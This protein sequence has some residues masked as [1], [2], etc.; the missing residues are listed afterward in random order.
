MRPRPRRDG[1]IAQSVRFFR[2]RL[3]ERHSNFIAA[4]GAEG[5]VLQ[6]SD[7][8]LETDSDRHRLFDRVHC[9]RDA[10]IASAARRLAREIAE[11]DDVSPLEAE[12][13]ALVMFA[14][15]IDLEHAGRF[16]KP[17]QSPRWLTRAV[18]LVHD[19]FRE[20]LLV[21]DVAQAAGVH[22]AHL[23]VMFRRVHRVPLGD[24]VRRLR[25]DWAADQLDTTDRPLSAIAA[26]AGF[27]DQAHLTRWFRRL[28]GVT[29]RAFRNT[30]R[31]RREQLRID[32][33]ATERVS[34]RTPSVPC[35]S[36][37]T[38]DPSLLTT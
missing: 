16:L 34:Y 18:E 28:T 27:A 38:P 15:S 3:G 32:N 35:V 1:S 36:R 29:P 9:F 33:G 10:Y 22:P 14:E 30:R 4:R 31:S 11:P 7:A 20:R 5:V 19:R 12:S 26:E 17:N 23:A 13:L 6:P 25:V 24:Y 2:N 37:R 8:A 21:D